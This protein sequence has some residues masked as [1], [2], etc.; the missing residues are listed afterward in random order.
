LL[1]VPDE[2]Y[3]FGSMKPPEPGHPPYQVRLGTNEPS[4]DA[5]A[6]VERAGEARFCPYDKS[7]AQ[8]TGYYFSPLKT[9]KQNVIGVLQIDVGKKT[10]LRED[11]R[12]LL[13]RLCTFVGASLT[14][15]FNW[16]E[17]MIRHR[18]QDALRASLSSSSTAEGV[19]KYLEG[20]LDALDLQMGH[21]RLANPVDYKL[22]LYAGLGEY[23]EAALQARPRI[24]YG[25]NS[26][27]TRA[28]KKKDGAII[29]ND[30]R[31]DPEHLSMIARWADA[32]DEA[33]VKLTRALKS[34]GSYANIAFSSERDFRGTINLVS[35]QPLFFKYAQKRVLHNIAEQVVFLI[36]H[37][38]RKVSEA[39]AL[40][41]AEEAS[42]AE[43]QTNKRLKFI[44][45][46]TS[47]LGWQDLDDFS[48]TLN[49][50]LDRFHTAVGATVASLYLWDAAR[51]L[52]VLRAEYNWNHPG[53][54]DV[55]NYAKDAGWFGVR[56]LQGEPRYIPDLVD[57]YKTKGYRRTE[58]DSMPGGHY[59]RYMFGQR[60]T[61]YH[62]VEV[63][64]IPLRNAHEEDIGVLAFYRPTGEKQPSGFNKT[65]VDMIQD[66]A[67]RPLVTGAAYDVAGLI[68]ALLQRLSDKTEK[69]E[70][71]RRKKISDVLSKHI[72]D[73]SADSFE[74]LLCR[75]VGEAYGTARADLYTI[76]PREDAP[77][78]RRLV[79]YISRDEPARASRPP[80]DRFFDAAVAVYTSKLDRA[81]VVEGDVRVK[82]KT[83]T[84]HERDDP[85]VAATE[86]LVE[87]M[88]LPLVL[89]RRHLWVL[90]MRWEVN[91]PQPL[92]AQDHLGSKY[93]WLLGN[94]L[95]KFSRLH[96]LTRERARAEEEAGRHL[97]SQRGLLGKVSVVAQ[98][99]HEWR[100]RIIE[101]KDKAEKIKGVEDV[102]ERRE[103][104]DDLLT[105][106]RDFSDGVSAILTLTEKMSL[107][108]RPSYLRELIETDDET[109]IISKKHGRTVRCTIDIPEGTRVHVTPL[110]MG[111]AFRNIVD[112]AV[113]ATEAA[114]DAL[115][116]IRAVIDKQNGHVEVSFTN[117]GKQI[118][119]KYS[120][121]INEERYEDENLVRQWGL[122]IAK[123]FAQHDGGNLTIQTPN[124]VETVM[125]FTLP[126]AGN[127]E[128]ARWTL[129]S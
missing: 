84:P 12:E 42:G 57:Y 48:S 59:S 6:Q 55:A 69:E 21:I 31:N 34:V 7:G 45:D 17:A 119:P 92:G 75:S 67:H 14:R 50:V 74:E 112:N 60:L 95:S 53:F 56:A 105:Y 1:I 66:P 78:V 93:L 114:A 124:G 77:D 91:A 2:R 126:V 72:E 46:V 120:D 39:K 43:Q 44:Q 5:A 115:L 4:D 113:Q 102:E 38:E 62:P 40:K 22:E 47:H 108:P 79:S 49:D 82:R 54:V 100:N 26:P 11:E 37:L 97:K 104:V 111:F 61:E 103:E 87:R 90:D 125:T 110:L 96:I 19:R 85:R 30:A 32:K 127:E 83:L 117:N 28:F 94:D 128:D 52:Y 33:A 29:I 24:D 86:G 25:D 123:S 81:E 107:Q 10:R 68:S 36:A 109:Q 3:T 20:T 89:G 58:D 35:D 18:L 8:T 41:E 88:C 76:A 116:S 51:N 98:F 106:L 15:I 80:A 70:Q 121:P 13:K 16:Q 71:E 129:E 63:I 99:A 101:L 23:Y 9:I 65:V 122:V 118:E 73:Q 64:G 27:T